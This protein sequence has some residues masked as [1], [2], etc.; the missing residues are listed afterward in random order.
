MA[1]HGTRDAG[2]P[3]TALPEPC[4]HQRHCGGRAAL[5]CVTWGKGLWLELELVLGGG[6]GGEVTLTKQR[7][8]KVSAGRSVWPPCLPPFLLPSLD[9]PT[10]LLGALHYAGCQ[11]FRDD[12]FQELV[13]WGTDAQ[14]STCRDG[15]GDNPKE[16]G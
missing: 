10:L 8:L 6:G 9:T 5:G 2:G 12:A 7:F 15:S 3:G 1:G 16:V 4:S 11:A 13:A 14:Q